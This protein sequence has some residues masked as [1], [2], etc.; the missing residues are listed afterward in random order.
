[1][2][3]RGE[4]RQKR[5][6]TTTTNSSSCWAAADTS[7]NKM[8]VLVDLWSIE[9]TKTI[10]ISRFFSLWSMLVSSFYA[11][12]SISHFGGGSF[13]YSL[14]FQIPYI[15]AIHSRVNWRGHRGPP[16]EKVDAGVPRQQKNKKTGRRRRKPVLIIHFCLITGTYCTALPSPRSWI[17]NQ[18]Y[19][20]FLRQTTIPR[21]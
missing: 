11:I 1:M 2:T 6:R 20:D 16:R 17:F 15:K 3:T 10:N 9:M 7:R 18:H 12:E 13:H 5:K 14:K 4:R 21:I 19:V 8:R